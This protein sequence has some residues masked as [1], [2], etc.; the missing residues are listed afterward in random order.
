MYKFSVLFLTL[1]HVAQLLFSIYER[2]NRS[3]VQTRVENFIY[4]INRILKDF[5]C[6]LQR[7]LLTFRE[8]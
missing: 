6:I 8:K 4:T 2:K 7:F 3:N 5:F 1:E